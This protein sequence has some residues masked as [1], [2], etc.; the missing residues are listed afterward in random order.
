MYRELWLEGRCPHSENKETA[1]KLGWGAL[2][3][4]R[5]SREAMGCFLD[6]PGHPPKKR[7][8]IEGCILDREPRGTRALKGP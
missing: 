2:I 1:W 7:G 8:R 6:P 5:E 4:F 3:L